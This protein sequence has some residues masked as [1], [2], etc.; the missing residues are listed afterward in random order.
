MLK[1]YSV[2]IFCCFV[3]VFNASAEVPTDAQL[4]ELFRVTKVESL[5]MDVRNQLE[6]NI[7]AGTQQ[8]MSQRQIPPAVV[9]FCL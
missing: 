8:L 1:Y 6:G 2:M 5:L 3:V 7:K 9:L 4:D